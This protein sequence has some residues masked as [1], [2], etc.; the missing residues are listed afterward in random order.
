[1][2]KQPSTQTDKYRELLLSWC[3]YLLKMQITREDDEYFGGFRCESCEHIHGRADNAIFPLVYTYFLTDDE[4]F[5]DGAKRLLSFRRLLTHEDGSVQND[6]GS[7]WKG[8]TVFSAINLYKT[9]KH[10]GKKLPADLHRELENIFAASACWV[11]ENVKLGFK[12]NI[13]YYCAACAVNA[14]YGEYFNSP[15][16]TSQ[17]RELL[18]YCMGNFTADGLITGE[19]Q[20]HDFHTEKGCAPI[21]IGYDIEESLPCLTD[22]A[23][24]LGDKDVLSKL[25]VYIRKALDFMLLDG[26]WDNSFGVRNNKWT[27]YGSRTSDGCIGAFTEL[28]R[29]EPVFFEA[30]ERTFEILRACTSDGALYGGPQYKENGQPPCVHHTFC[31]AAALADALC[32]GLSE[33]ERIS[34]PCDSDRLDFKYYPELDTY[35][36]Y[37]GPWTAAVTAYD[38]STYTYPRG[39][40]HA[41]G[42]ALSMLY[43][44]GMG[45]VIAGS[46]YEYKPTEIYNMQLPQNVEHR[47]LIPRCEYEKNG[48]KY[49]TCLDGGA[50]VN[51]TKDADSVCVSVRAKFC[52]VEE[53]RAEDPDLIAGFEYIFSPNGVKM[54]V[55]INRPDAEIYFVLPVIKDT[56]TPVTDSKYICRD[57]FF[58]VGGFAAK[59]YTFSLDKKITIYLGGTDNE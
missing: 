43:H 16:Y 11:H 19:G 27:Y 12:A 26:G 2:T 37:A 49:A 51:V 22:A 30:A 21:D 14:M 38:Y 40:A 24:I 55:Q 10:F 34:L 58:L 4:R 44:R 8:I 18:A 52:S 9:L 39:A 13:N 31:H 29:I 42:G 28:G 50:K 17:A 25:C 15:K 47:T 48:I 54:T 32:R 45:A 35:K 56:A 7:Q 59:E 53:K 1:M 23:V 3:E 33:H 6:F 41:S 20:P 5:L 36:I 57:I 46:V